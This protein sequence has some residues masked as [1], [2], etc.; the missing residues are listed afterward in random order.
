[1]DAGADAHFPGHGQRRPPAPVFRRRAPRAQDAR[2]EY[3]AGGRVG[4]AGGGLYAHRRA[5]RTHQLRHA[6]RLC[7]GVPGRVAP[8]PPRTGPRTA[9][10]GAGP[11]GDCAAGHPHQ[12]PAHRHAQPPLAGAGRR[13]AGDGP[14]GILRLQPPP[15]PSAPAV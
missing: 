3:G 9:F 15:Q 14:A 10:P 11:R 4:V 12:R 6:V 2:Q 5:E 8:A 1:D 13:L 7:H